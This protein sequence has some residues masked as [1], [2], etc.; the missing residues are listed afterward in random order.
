MSTADALI[1]RARDLAEV[2]AAL[3][4]ARSG[5]GGLLLLAGEAGVGKTTV[6]T[7]ALAGST[8]RVLVGEALP[9]A[10][11]PYGPVVTA[12]RSFL[13]SDPQG[14]RDCGPL[15]SYLALILPE[16]GPAPEPSDRATLFEAIRCAF[17]TIARRGPAAVLLDDL[18]WADEATLELLPA[19]ASSLEEEA[20][21]VI[22]A[23]RSDELRRGHPVRRLRA[24]LRRG[25][26][27]PGLTVGPL[28]ARQTRGL[29]PR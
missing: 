25:G 5:R 4:A 15:S 22:G 29:P 12:L 9:Q 13:R 21:L 27:L 18:Q 28:F 10:T 17:E 1:G 24:E 11:P 3:A 8:T 19:L 6:A 2:D 23:Y 14:L 16:L 26:R 7:T 20:M